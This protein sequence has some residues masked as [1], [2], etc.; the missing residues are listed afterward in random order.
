[1][2][3]RSPR[4]DEKFSRGWVE[5]LK[6]DK[7]IIDEERETIEQTVQH[8]IHQSPRPGSKPPKSSSS[9]SHH[10]IS[11]GRVCDQP[12]SPKY[13]QDQT[14]GNFWGPLLSTQQTQ[15]SERIQQLETLLNQKQDR[16]DALE[17]HLEQT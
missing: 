15:L 9:S 2:S 12:F 6:I 13:K 10:Q 16:I 11:P 14:T 1:V 17:A 7:D 5:Q 8:T 4:S 3:Q